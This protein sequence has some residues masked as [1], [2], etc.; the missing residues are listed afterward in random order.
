[1]EL[2]D[3][4]VE[5]AEKAGVNVEMISPAHEEGEMLLKSFGGV[6]ALLKYRV[7]S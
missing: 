6:A 2:L 4:L 3:V 1:R 7:S 5:E